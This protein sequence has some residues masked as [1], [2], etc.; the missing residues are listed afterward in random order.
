MKRNFKKMIPIS[1]VLLMMAGTSASAQTQAKGNAA[2]RAPAV[3]ERMEPEQALY[4]LLMAEIA[5]QRGENA[6]ALRGLMELA[7][8]TRDARVARRAVEMAFQARDMEAAIDASLLWLD[9]QPDATL[10]KQALAG[11]IGMHGNADNLA[12]NLR[13]AFA[14][15]ER[16]PALFMHVNGLLA[17]VNDK[18]RTATIALVEELSRPH[19][20]LPEAHYALAMAYLGAEDVPRAMESANRALALRND[21]DLGAVL[22]SRILR[23]HPKPDALDQAS[24][25]LAGFVKSHPTSVEA[26]LQYARLLFAQNALL[27]AR[28]QFRAIARLDPR[29]SDHAYA[30]ALMSQQIEDWADAEAQLKR[31]LE[32]GPK[33]ANA[34]RYSLGTVVAAQQKVDA[35]IEWFRQVGAGEYFV[36]AQLK[37]ANA[38]VKRD[39]LA[40]GRKFLTE[41]RQVEYEDPSANH[42]LI[43]AEAQ[44]LRDAKL[45]ADAY[46]F[47]GKAVEQQPDVPDLLYDRAMVAEKLNR[48]ES[49]EADLR[50]VIELKP[51]HAHALNALGYTFA[52]RNIRLDEA[53]QL[54]KKAIALE[55]S[56]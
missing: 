9:L 36:N 37:I 18:D 1:A 40:A 46:D 3:A 48:L 27:S 25:Y 11:A 5:G 6:L 21:W 17:R 4:R 45:F 32:L 12:A 50:R 47:L 14:A 39:G 31:A 52:E 22:K 44:L 24:D 34:V 33:D 29:N 13:R 16:A 7:S 38:L 42:Q 10:P 8:S 19:A 53:E 49:M 51:E 55:P 35:A 2:R 56:D 20:K 23:A 43:L 28:E 41:A 54:V 15:A 26:R 30:I